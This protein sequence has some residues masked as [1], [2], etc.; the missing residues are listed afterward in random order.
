[1]SSVRIDGAEHFDEESIKACLA[2]HERERFG[3]VLGGAPTPQCGVPPFDA[4]RMPVNLWAWPWTD[5]PL[6]NQT[7]FERDQDRI[8]R[9]YQ[10][11]GYYGA[12]ITDADVA[13]I[14]A[15]YGLQI[16]AI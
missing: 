16:P 4:T 1:M 7:A 8:E 3:F 2:T 9:W 10:A 11:R 6:F 12:Q 13:R 14:N 5:W 15:E